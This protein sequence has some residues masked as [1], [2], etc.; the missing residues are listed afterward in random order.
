MIPSHI[1]GTETACVSAQ[2]SPGAA[3]CWD[4]LC[5][6]AL[7]V[8]PLLLAIGFYYR[9]VWQR[10]AQLPL[11]GDAW[12][13]AYQLEQAGD[14]HGMWW[15]LGN[16]GLIGQPYATIAAKHP[17]IY[18]GV[19]LILLGS[20]TSRFL[21]PAANYH[22]MVVLVLAFNGWIAAWL[23]R[24]LTQSY[25]WAVVAVVLLTLNG[26]TAFRLNG[27][28]HLF[29]HGWVL[30]AVWAFA[31][32][33]SAPSLRRGVIL[34]VCAALVLQGSFYFGF[35]LTL[36]LS[37]IGV[38]CLFARRWSRQQWLALGVACSVYAVLGAALT[39][40]VWTTNRNTPLSD[41]YFHRYSSEN[42]MYNSAPWQYFV[43][44]HLK[45]PA[46]DGEAPFLPIGEGWNFPGYVILLAIAV[47]VIGRV[48]GW[49]FDAVSSRFVD[50][51]MGLTAVL[52]IFSL[53]GGPSL[54]ASTWVSCFRCYGR[55]G[56]I[57][58]GLWCVA[59][60]LILSQA[61]RT[62][63]HAW[64]RSALM[65]GLLALAG[66]DG[67][68][69]QQVYY[70]VSPP[71]TPAWVDW[72]A[73][74][75]ADVRL[76]AFSTWEGNRLGYQANWF[77]DS[78]YYRTIHKH[79]ALNGCEFNL[80]EADL[81]LL[82]ASYEDMNPAGLRFIASLG[83][84][85]LAFHQEYLDTHAWIAALPW[86]DRTSVRE[87]W[88]FFR[89]NS[90]LARFP[91]ISMQVLLSQQKPD[92]APERVP[93]ACWITEQLQL[94]RTVVVGANA[95]ARLA[96]EDGAGKL[97][98][99][100]ATALFQHIL[101]PDL[102]AYTIQTPGKPGP[103]SLVF[104]DEEGRRLHVK[105]FEVTA[106]L[107]TG[108]QAYADRN[109]PLKAALE[110]LPGEHTGCRVVLENATPFYLQAFGDRPQAEHSVRSHPGMFDLRTPW[111]GCLSL[112]IWYHPAQADLPPREI[113]LLLPH[114]IPPQGRVSLLLLDEL[115]AGS[116]GYKI[117]NGSSGEHSLDSVFGKDHCAIVDVRTEAVG[118]PLFT[119]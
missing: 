41:L 100:P 67:F 6:G 111:A 28:L 101:G 89:T 20:L 15:K 76:A 1:P 86:L 78:L 38:I 94:D 25:L 34:G 27:H 82:G 40:P 119:P 7:V 48:R 36:A 60:P 79:Q 110:K 70:Y 50:L 108:K 55:A 69:G 51:L 21:T 112:V 23:V 91:A 114:D 17:G 44:P 29:K 4:L 9:P 57:A 13:Y 75:P 59:A 24:R 26:S 102:P 14:L 64:L 61:L 31:R 2:R 109:P 116:T 52:V 33:L 105:H 66:Y 72:L 63:R 12:L 18:E 107:F 84:D 71:A 83:Y 97:V 90:A 77:W 95:R 98:S 8:L 45:F 92:A 42:M 56:L 11:D 58:V 47:Y 49:R 32:C 88:H 16:D 106:E 73:E 115:F 85:S 118:N 3:S 62:L 54:I 104:M 68:H 37:V 65:L 117:V 81:R 30:L 46:K 99:R 22:L 103:Y 5:R 96:W 93:P 43:A 10:G 53:K 74:Q 113:R 39:F 87:G 80:L 19:D 35:L